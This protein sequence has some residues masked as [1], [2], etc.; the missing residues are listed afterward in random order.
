M[1]RRSVFVL[2][3]GVGLLLVF[4]LTRPQPQ[5][6]VVPALFEPSAGSL[7]DSPSVTLVGSAQPN[8][9]VEIW[10]D[11]LKASLIASDDAGRWSSEVNLGGPGDHLLQ[12]KAVDADRKVLAEGEELSLGVR[13]APLSSTGTTITAPAD[14]STLDSG[15]GVFSGSGP[16]GMT[17]AVLVE[18]RVVGRV[19]VR[20]NGRWTFAY[21]FRQAGEY[22]VRARAID[23]QQNILSES[24]IV[25]VTV[26]E[27]SAERAGCPCTLRLS[28]NA[29]EATFTLRRESGEV[30]SSRSSPYAAFTNLPAGSYRY[31]VEAP[32]FQSYE[33]TAKIPD[34]RV[35]S[36]WLEASP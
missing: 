26:P 14:G 24:S 33:G 34:N 4:V 35:L 25:R 22:N 36:V 1:S 21:D 2:L 7:L 20:A 5:P 10:I 8:S 12:L 13:G 18:E 9:L 31:T 27:A 32:G 6:A 16:V 17:V 29:P 15:I 3:G 23:L 30:V 19:P 28:T 11:G